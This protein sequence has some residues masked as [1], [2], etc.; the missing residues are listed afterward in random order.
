MLQL[1]K[2]EGKRGEAGWLVASQGAGADRDREAE[3]GRHAL[4]L[5]RTVGAPSS[6]PL[7]LSDAE[8]PSERPPF[9]KTFTKRRSGEWG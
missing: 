3:A 9:M 5:R 1:R 7:L 6:G 2:Q 8:A 4:L